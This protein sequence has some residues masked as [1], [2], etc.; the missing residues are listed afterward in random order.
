MFTVL[1]FQIK[2][3]KYDSEI[4]KIWNALY[5]SQ[6][7]HQVRIKSTRKKQAIV[8]NRKTKYKKKTI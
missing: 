3:K 2:K 7:V 6:M 5:L 8:T 1:G 4:T